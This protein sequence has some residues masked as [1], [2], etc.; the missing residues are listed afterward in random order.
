[1]NI[2]NLE[3]VIEITQFLNQILFKDPGK[4]RSMEATLCFRTRNEYHEMS[5]LMAI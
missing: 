4:Q 2:P 5:S 3:T 1:M